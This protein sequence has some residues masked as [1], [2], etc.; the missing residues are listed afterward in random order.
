[1]KPN[2]FDCIRKVYYARATQLIFPFAGGS[3]AHQFE[4]TLKFVENCRLQ[5]NYFAAT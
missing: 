1:M 3:A 4:V 2:T 5:K